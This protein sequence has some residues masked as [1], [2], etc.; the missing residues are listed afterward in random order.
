MSSLELVRYNNKI[1]WNQ[2]KEN[3]IRMFKSKM[4]LNNKFNFSFFD[5][6][7]LGMKDL[8]NFSYPVVSDN[9]KSHKTKKTKC[10]K[11]TIF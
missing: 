11:C 6:N 3:D 9:L 7:E 8:D 2:I 1:N 4:S 10:L 5:V